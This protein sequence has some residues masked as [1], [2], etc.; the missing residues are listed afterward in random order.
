MKR[1][2]C[3]VVIVTVFMPRLSAQFPN[4]VL[5]NS[6]SNAAGTGTLPV[7]SK[8][9][10][11]TVSMTGTAGPFVP[12]VSAG[13]PYPGNYNWVISKVINA[14]W[15]SYPHTCP[16][17]GSW[18]WSPAEHSCLNPD[19]MDLY[20]RLKFN[21]PASGEDPLY[22]PGEYCLTF[23]F[24][25]DNCV[26][27]VFVNGNS[28]YLT[29]ENSPYWAYSYQ[30]NGNFKVPLCDHWQS[31]SNEV[32]VHVKSGNGMAPTWE[33]LLAS[34]AEGVPVGN[35]TINYPDR[36]VIKPGPA[37]NNINISQ[38]QRGNT[39]E[40][41]DL[42]GRQIVT[43]RAEAGEI[44]ISLNGVQPGLYLIKVSNNY[45]SACKKVVIR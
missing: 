11:W 44:N 4:T 38:I 34:V 15:I 39:V 42:S 3:F 28:T 40:I 6:A 14:N 13:N 1:I 25:A 45:Q 8:D 18:P 41:L 5:F 10:N 9:L 37:L 22:S 26:Y 35:P 32:L 24:Y 29:T 16:P 12:A 36:F 43:S 33:G 19:Y 7:S 23:D 30:L 20:Y 2:I 17:V 31:G 21:L 27:E